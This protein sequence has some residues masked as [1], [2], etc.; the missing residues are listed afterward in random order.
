MSLRVV[1]ISA[2]Q[3][4]K[5]P[6]EKH[7][8]ID[9]VDPASLFNACR[10]AAILA[11]QKI[12]AWGESNWAVSRQQR[13][14]KLLL[15][16]SLLESMPYFEKLLMQEQPNLLLIGAMSLC[17]PGAIAC[18]KRA[19]EIFGDKIFI[20]LGGWHASETIYVHASQPSIVRHHVSSPTWLMQHNLIPSVFD[21]VI[22]GSGEFVIA[23]LGEMIASLIKKGQPLHKLCHEL[24]AHKQITGRWIASFV[25]AGQIIDVQSRAYPIDYNQLVPPCSLFGVGSSFNVFDGALTAHVF[26][27]TGRGCAYDCYFCSERRSVNGPLLQVQQAP[28]R[29][30]RQLEAACR[31]IQTDNPGK[32]A[33][34]FVEDSV[35]LT[36]KIHNLHALADLLEANPLPIHFGGQLTIP[37]ILARQE[38]LLRLKECGLNYF[39]VGLET[40]APNE[41]GGM[42]KAFGQLGEHWIYSAEKVLEFF[43]TN[44]IRYG[45]ALLFGLG[46]P[47]GRRLQLLSTIKN[48]QERYQLPYPVSLN[49][50]TQHPLMGNDGGAN[51]HYIDWGI[52]DDSFL[53]AFAGFGEASTLYPLVNVLSPRLAEVQEIAKFAARLNSLSC[54][55]T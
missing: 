3:W 34:A 48:W 27:D 1:A 32:Q 53:E 16:N 4:I 9:S 42:N 30:Y 15:M 47:H 45:C 10:V 29:L 18:A 26:S 8:N 49:W 21:L 6:P 37:Q 25:K 23:I 22:S 36:G 20:V 24:E 12:G 54:N 41:I 52:S 51:Y 14:K 7:Y 28:H 5:K 17:F 35:L 39:F 55:R 31:T 38:V 13:R 19:K 46:E 11:D 40:L 33:S 44:G 2:P 50:A 43:A